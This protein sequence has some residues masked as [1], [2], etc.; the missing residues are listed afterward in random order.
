MDGVKHV[1]I[2]ITHMHSDH[3][4]SLG[5]FIGFCFWKYKITS[6]VYFKEKKN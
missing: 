5:G 6:K 4:G 2:L 3:V 1:H